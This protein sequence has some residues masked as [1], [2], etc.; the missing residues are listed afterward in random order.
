VAQA[1]PLLRF[2]RPGWR[3]HRGPSTHAHFG[4]QRHRL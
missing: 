1:Q 4:R 2:A 3:S